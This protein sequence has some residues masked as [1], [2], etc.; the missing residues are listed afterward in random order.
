MVTYPRVRTRTRVAIADHQPIRRHAIRNLL[1][2]MPG[3]QVVCEPDN[4]KGIFESCAAG[5]PDLLLLDGALLD[6]GGDALRRLVGDHGTTRTIVLAAAGNDAEV[7]RLAD[8]GAWGVVPRELA[9][10]RLLDCL[11][12]VMRGER[13]IIRRSGVTARP[14]TRTRTG[15]PSPALTPRQ[16]EVALL[17]AGGA[18]NKAIALQLHLTEQSVK[19]CVR[20]IFRKL[21]V[22]SRVALSLAIAGRSVE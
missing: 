6:Q 19:N 14:A 20:V 4:V 10:E 12:N 3:L 5:G 1:A 16:N 22:S 9:S 18:T 8:L 13:M 11:R 2:G 15:N 21:R 7:Q 17:L